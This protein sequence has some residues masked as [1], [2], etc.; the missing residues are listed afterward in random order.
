MSKS[1]TLGDLAGI[2]LNFPFKLGSFEA[3]EEVS[4]GVDDA[5]VLVEEKDFV[6]RGVDL[7]DLSN[8]SCVM[9]RDLA[10][11]PLNFPL[12]LGRLEDLEALGEGGE[13]MVFFAPIFY[14]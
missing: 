2:P 12:R 7:V 8:V 10:G 6:R 9:L 4:E 5:C 11:V 1:D 14:F 13:D 3:R